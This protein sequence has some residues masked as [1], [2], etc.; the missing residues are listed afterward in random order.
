M[1]KPFT[2][3]AFTLLVLLSNSSFANISDFGAWSGT[4]THI[5]LSQESPF[6]L[7]SELQ[8]RVQQDLVASRGNRML[9]RTG[10]R[11][12]L[13]PAWSITLGHAWT[14]NLSPF[15]NENRIWQQA[16]TQSRFGS[17]LF[18]SRTRFEQRWIEGIQ[19]TSH[20]FRELIRFNYELNPDFSIASWDE[21]F[22]NLNQPQANTRL[23]FD[24]NRAFLGINIGI[25][26]KTRLETGYM[27]NHIATGNVAIEPLTAHLWVLYLF[28]E[29]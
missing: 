23:G 10:L 13:N 9:F 28:T 6:A 21:L 1:A 26:G 25:G 2:I 14:P 17:W 4:F 12:T 8:T 11:Y 5:R 29:I 16:Q 19:S 3:F 27:H 22:I 15:K 18:M 24:Q 20:R 7:Y